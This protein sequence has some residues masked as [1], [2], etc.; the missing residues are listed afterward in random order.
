MVVLNCKI[1]SFLLLKLDDQKTYIITLVVPLTN[2]TLIYIIF[3][4]VE[5]FKNNFFQ[6]KYI[7]I[8]K[9]NSE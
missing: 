2:L 3:R 4:N 8:V 6:I 9:E 5:I 7:Y 1:L